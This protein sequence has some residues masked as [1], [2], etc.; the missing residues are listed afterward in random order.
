MLND[1]LTDF[2]ESCD[3]MAKK[4]A[5][6]GIERTLSTVRKESRGQQKALKRAATEEM[7]NV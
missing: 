2:K 6:A 5:K 7:K 4:D 3:S 1:V